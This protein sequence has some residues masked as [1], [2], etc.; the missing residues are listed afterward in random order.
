MVW[1]GELYIFV[2][3]WKIIKILDLY[4]RFLYNNMKYVYMYTLH[5]HLIQSWGRHYEV[6]DTLSNHI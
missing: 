2:V 6:S 1:W 4:V 3:H 5:T